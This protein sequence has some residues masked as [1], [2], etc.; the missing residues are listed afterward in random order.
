MAI[1]K[2]GFLWVGTFN[3]L[4]L[5]DGYGVTTYTREDFPELASNNIIHITCDSRNRLWLASLEGVSW[6]DEKRK[7][8]R[9]LLQDTI[10]KFGCRTII[11]TKTLGYILFTN[12]GQFYFDQKKNKWALLDWIPPELIF[13]KFMDAA[14]LDENKIIFTTTD[15]VIIIDYQN[16]KV[17]FQEPVEKAVSACAINKNQIAIGIYTGLVRIV[18]VSTKEIVHEYHL[19]EES[20]KTSKTYLTEVRLAANGDLLVASGFA[21]LLTIDKNGNINRY[22]HHPINPRSIASNNV[23]R[24]LAGNNGEV[25]AGT[26]TAGISI[27]NI[28]N[29][30]AG[31][32]NIFRDKA[33]NFF[34][35]YINCIAEDKNGILWLAAEDR[36]IRWDKEKDISKFYYYYYYNYPVTGTQREDIR[37]LC[38]DKKGRLW[39]A[40]AGSGIALFDEKSGRFNIVKRDTSLGLAVKTNVIIDLYCA[41]D[42]LIWVAT[43]GGLYTIN[44]ENFSINTFRDHILWKEIYGK[45]VNTFLEDEKGRMW[46]GMWTDGIYCY[47]PKNE[48]LSHYTRKE[49]LG[50]NGCVALMNDRKG[51]IYAGTPDGF[52][53]ILPSGKIESYSRANGLR[54]ERC[55]NIL[56]DNNGNIWISNF[57][58]LVRYNP[59]MKTIQVFD[60]NVDLSRDGFRPLSSIKTSRG[61]LL[62]GGQTGVNYFFTG[63]L[64]NYPSLIKVNIYQA[65]LQDSIVITSANEN[66]KLRYADNSILFRF[67]AINLCGS[68]NTRYQYKLEG[69]DHDW[70]KG[71]DIRQ[72]RYPSLPPGDFIFRVKASIDGVNW[73]DSSN[74]V[75]VSI[76][77]PLWHRWW[78]IAASL[79]VLSAGAYLF[80]RYRSKKLKR[81][82][83][84]LETEQAI[85][86]F[87]SSMYEQQTVDTILW[88][89]ARNCIG[90]LKFED[91]VIY[92]M[93]KRKNVLVQKAAYGP[94]SPR[95]FEIDK[96]IEIPPGKGIVGSVAM[97]GKPEIIRD[98]T[99]DSRYIIDDERRYSE[100][101]VPIISDG[102]ILGVIDCE[103]S[104]KSFFTQKHLS[105]LTTIASLCANKIVR[106]RAEEEKEH[107]QLILMDTQRKMTEVEMQA[108]RAQMNP[109]F[110]FNC[111]NSI[112]RYIVKSDQVTASYY[113]TK[114]AK[115]IRLILDNSNSKTVI[116]SHELEAL[117]LYIEMEALRFDKKF[118]YQVTVDEN[119]NPDSVELPPL[120]I[121]PYVEN[122]IWH[123]LLHKEGEG[124]L[125]IHVSLVSETILEC[126]IEDNGIGREKAKELK[127]KSA[128][129]RKSLGLKLTESRLS[130]LN[131]FAELNASIDIVDLKTADSKPAGTKVILKIP[132]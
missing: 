75:A 28:F 48:Q 78:F 95:Q 6:L 36:L 99:K 111:L 35:S 13:K 37:S 85:N 113:L 67:T 132:V 58:C 9:V 84:E 45:R 41:S 34:D 130:L 125:K 47:D 76:I 103:H 64:M 83:E 74:Q 91:C 43:P 29:K 68:R 80:F 42:G 82:K 4:N 96:P 121:Q 114:F 119:V 79:I 65:D 100:I 126:V 22:T 70:Q 15:V 14:P 120:I 117:K 108:L 12:L 106:A 104:K 61:E 3:G 89:V 33:G 107:A 87:A 57:K 8:H 7:I 66:I 26:F 63:Q 77:P 71:T 46:I 27:F 129:T 73:I 118:S 127:S 60:E 24:V 122:A 31:Y 109:H 55:E 62:W 98:T 21:G 116:L 86:Y 94:K 81:Q 92:L 128:T 102:K 18:D 38:F 131:K 69:Y 44:P 20:Q 105:I 19:I 51:N 32:T 59:Q 112:N 11:E 115:L 72:A 1:D 110:I 49:G 52:N 30:A 40:A 2:N 10:S 123:G 93:D 25:I 88:D 54:Y 50:D 97:S 23:F 56:E 101:S 5:Y 17:I 90:R 39:L 16:K 124:R 53:V